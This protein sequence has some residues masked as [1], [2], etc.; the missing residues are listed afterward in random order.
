MVKKVAIN[1]NEDTPGDA[2]KERGHGVIDES[3]WKDFDE[4]VDNNCQ[5]W[6]GLRYVKGVIDICEIM[7]DESMPIEQRRRKAYDLFQ[8]QAHN[9]C[10]AHM[11]MDALRHLCTDGETLADEI[12]DFKY[13]PNGSLSERRAYEERMKPIRERERKIRKDLLDHRKVHE[14]TRV[15]GSGREL[16]TVPVYTTN[17][18]MFLV[19]LPYRYTRE[20]CHELL[21][22]I[23]TRFGL[24]YGVFN[25]VPMFSFDTPDTFF[26]RQHNGMTHEDY[27]EFLDACR[28]DLRS[29]TDKA[30]QIL[31]ERTWKHLGKRY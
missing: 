13:D 31:K 2:L 14:Y 25:N 7:H 11:T 16:G 8:E 15:D 28:S 29:D 4:M 26:R 6:S 10:T 3:R 17:S 24:C 5:S 18:G 1:N 30:K 20:Q 27:K 21:W 9:G 23:S 22:F 19:E 12:A